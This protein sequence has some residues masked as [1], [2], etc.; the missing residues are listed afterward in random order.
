MDWTPILAAAVGSGITLAGIFLASELE[1]R[2]ETR[3]SAERREDERQARIRERRLGDLEETRAVLVAQLSWLER[4]VVLGD[5]NTTSPDV[6]TLTRYNINLVGDAAVIR[7]YGEV[8]RDL[9][10]ALPMNRLDT[11]GDTLRNALGRTLVELDLDQV[12]RISRVRAELLSALD[13]Q[14]GHVLR[15]EPLDK[16]TEAELT[17]IAES[18]A[19]VEVMRERQA[20]ASS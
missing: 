3:R 14:E 13:R 17:S 6:D 18:D 4:R 16:M 7:T 1:A 11:I 15:D 5:V 10:S 8:V 12:Q 2:R 20:G 9:S 19:F